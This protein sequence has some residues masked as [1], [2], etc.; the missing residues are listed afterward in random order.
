MKRALPLDVRHRRS[1][2]I[3]LVIV[4]KTST[5]SMWLKGDFR[6]R[7][8][9]VLKPERDFWQGMAATQSLPAAT[10]LSTEGEKVRLF[11]ERGET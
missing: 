7:A 3:V 6:T 9:C 10:A 4:I 1:R 5:P 11:E 2:C 8:F